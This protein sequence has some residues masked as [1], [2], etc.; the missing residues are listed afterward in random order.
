MTKPDREGLKSLTELCQQ[1][2]RNTFL[3][4]YDPS[5]GDYRQ[6]TLVEHHENI[7]GL[8][9]S[10]FVPESIATQYDVARNL[11]QYAW[12]EYRFYV[13]A[14][15][16][17]L[18]VLELA[19]RTRIDSDDLKEYIKE[20]KAQ[21][22]E[23]K[24]SFNATKG[25]KLYIE[26][27]RDRQLISEDGF[28]ANEH[29]PYR[30]AKWRYEGELIK[31]IT[32]QGLSEVNYNEDDICITDEDRTRNHL[33]HLVKSINKIRNNYAHGATT[34]HNSVLGTFV[35]VRDFI[36]QMYSVSYK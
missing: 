1:D 8:S 36:N 13:E 6:T 28:S 23:T 29:L 14:E 7:S 27:C 11:Y 18:T 22:K 19:L 10:A 17:V 26:Y 30:R 16:K 15:A 20:R 2:I 25:L 21:A 32:E 35:D 31:R 34:L 4:R 5:I 3:H 9:L 12:F 24:I 33:E